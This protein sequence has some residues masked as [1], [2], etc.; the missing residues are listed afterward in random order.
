MFVDATSEKERMEALAPVITG[1][2]GQ[3]PTFYALFHL[4]S[5]MVTV[6]S[7]WLYILSKSSR[8]EV[9]AGMIQSKYQS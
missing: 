1:S 9:G 7:G 6:H 4:D 5:M 2:G 8:H 3:L